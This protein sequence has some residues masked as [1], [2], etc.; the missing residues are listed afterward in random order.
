[1]RDFTDLTR[2]LNYQVGIDLGGTYY[3]TDQLGLFVHFNARY[4][5]NNMLERDNFP[6][7]TIYSF[8]SNLGLKYSF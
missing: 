8:G 4:M 7:E 2:D 1:V 3:F 6:R 5:I